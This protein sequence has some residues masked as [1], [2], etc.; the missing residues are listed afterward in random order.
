MEVKALPE[1]KGSG[2]NVVIFFITKRKTASLKQ[3]DRNEITLRERTS[4]MLLHQGTDPTHLQNQ[5]LDFSVLNSVT[6]SIL[7]PLVGD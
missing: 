6:V 5:H 7:S 1:R 4:K 2:G 3:K